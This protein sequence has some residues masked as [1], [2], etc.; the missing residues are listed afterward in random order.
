M[1]PFLIYIMQIKIKL[2]DSTLNYKSFSYKYNHET[3]IDHEIKYTIN[4]FHETLFNSLEIIFYEDNMFFKNAV[5]YVEIH[6]TKLK[7]GILYFDIYSGEYSS[8]FCSY[9]EKRKVGKVKLEIEITKQGQFSYFDDDSKAQLYPLAEVKQKKNILFNNMFISLFIDKSTISVYESYFYK[10]W[11]I[12]KVISKGSIMCHF[13]F[14]YG[15]FLLEQYYK[16]LSLKRSIKDAESIDTKK[17]TD[18]KFYSDTNLLLNKKENDI[19]PDNFYRKDMSSKHEI[20]DT[21]FYEYYLNKYYFA[22]APYARFVLLNLIEK[23]R[24]VTEKV[25]EPR[26]TILSYLDISNDDLLYIKLKSKTPHI[27]FYDQ[28]ENEIVVSIRGTQNH[29]DALNDL[30]C[31]YSEFFKGYAHSGFIKLANYF[32]DNFLGDIEV[33]ILTKRVNRV[34]FTGQSLGGALAMLVYMIIKE[35]NLLNNYELRVISFQSPPIISKKLIKND[36]NIVNISYGYDI[37]SRL[38]FGSL[39]DL[40]FLSISI[41]KMNKVN[42][43]MDDNINAVKE[44]LEKQDLHP[45]LYLPGKLYHLKKE[46]NHVLCQNVDF[47]FYNDIIVNKWCFFHHSFTEIIKAFNGG[48]K[49]RKNC[50]SS[51]DYNS[52]K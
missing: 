49:D 19:N 43:N 28:K 3:F 41:S 47:M 25:R 18:V 8:L 6:N 35:K 4:S 44:Y 32:I 42:K 17:L 13:N 31:E 9:G 36:Y 5:G 37:V 30:D 38:S 46:N 50:K 29:L 52:I 20:R 34:L 45:K 11:N 7:P 51:H 21:C 2:L 15:L 40:K 23:R 22:I 27:V 26:K 48:I 1:Y 12:Y 10:I 14:W 33:E 16:N 24:K 39:L